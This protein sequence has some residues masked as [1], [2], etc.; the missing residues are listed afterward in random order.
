MQLIQPDWPAIAGVAAA[1]S[2]RNGG[3]S[4]APYHSLNLGAHVGDSA[5]QVQANRS[6]FSQALG[7]AQQ[8]AW[9]EQVHGITVLQLHANSPAGQQA[10]ACFTTAPN[11]PCAIM[12]ADCLPLLLA[13]R[14][15]SVVAA[16]H[17]GWRGLCNGVIEATL[18]ALPLPA[19]QFQA[20]LGPA[21]GPTAFEVGSE[22][23]EAFLAVHAEDAAAFV[24]Q[25]PRYLA[26]LYQLARARLQRA[27]VGQVYGGQH[28]T[29][30][31]ADLFFS[32]RRSAPTGRMASVIWRTAL[33]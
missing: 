4:T 1:S 14:C 26:D 10:D 11:V 32:H 33:P 5:V 25:G 16:A 9:L 23:R 13:S 18:A 19:Q 21:I 15:G 7:L 3:Y 31:E 12:T 30:S 28:C 6:R 29:A 22:V 20:W 17:A 27:G 24:A 2:T 8:P